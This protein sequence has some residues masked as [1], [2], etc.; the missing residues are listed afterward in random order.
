ML[1]QG[2]ALLTLALRL[3][4]PHKEND[5]VMAGMLKE[6][7]GK[8][9]MPMPEMAAE[10]E[11]ESPEMEKLEAAEPVDLSS[12]SDDMLMQELAKRGLA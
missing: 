11:G 9:D 10:A 5:M 2:V 8:E 1:N 12:V 7:L 4:R 6:K 3:N